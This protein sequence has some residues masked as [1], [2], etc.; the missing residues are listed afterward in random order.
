VKG[1]I[2]NVFLVWGAGRSH[3]GAGRSCHPRHI[4]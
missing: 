1:T 4:L 2:V 3:G